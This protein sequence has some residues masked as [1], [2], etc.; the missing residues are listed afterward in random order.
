MRKHLYLCYY[1]LVDKAPLNNQTQSR[2]LKTLGRKIIRFEKIRFA[3]VGAVNTTVDFSVFFSLVTFLGFHS[4]LANIFSTSTALTVSFLLNKT[5]V[6]G[7]SGT[8]K[9]GQIILFVVV[10]LTGLWCL[11]S[12]II[13]VV[14]D[15][16]HVVFGVTGGL[17]LLAAKVSATSFS[18]VW[19]Y[20]W[21][22]KVIFRKPKHSS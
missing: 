2:S 7:S 14:S 18:M 10:T 12:L 3:L 13:L 20:L 6:F 16:M 5:A 1:I 19:N 4:V 22:S 8:P 17:G 15:L 11:Q 9:P 21:Y